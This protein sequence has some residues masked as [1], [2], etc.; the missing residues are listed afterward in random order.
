M[1]ITIEITEEDYNIIQTTETNLE[2]E[3]DVLERLLDSIYNGTVVEEIEVLKKEPCEDAISREDTM[4]ALRADPSFICSG[5]KLNAIRV[6]E[7]MSPVRSLL[8]RMN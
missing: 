5:D 1:K 2:E 8:P 6:V 7:G 4:T 3:S